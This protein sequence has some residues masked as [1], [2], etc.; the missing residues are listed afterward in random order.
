[1]KPQTAGSDLGLLRYAFTINPDGDQ[2]TLNELKRVLSGYLLQYAP[3][4][5]D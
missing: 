4:R 1:M 5:R 3:H 2:V